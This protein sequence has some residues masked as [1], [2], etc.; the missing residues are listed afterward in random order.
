MVLCAA[1][2]LTRS[3][4]VAASLTLA[5]CAAWGQGDSGLQGELAESRADA[6]NAQ[7]QVE[8]LEARLVQLE[9][10]QASVGSRSTQARV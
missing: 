3:L 2:R 4:T 8:A 10:A 6:Q 9:R 1:R 5:G 7:A